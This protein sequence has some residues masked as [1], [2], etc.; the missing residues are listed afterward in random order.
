MKLEEQQ[1]E[2]LKQ[3]N[4]ALIHLKLE[5]GDVEIRKSALLRE[6]DGVRTLMLEQEQELVKEYVPDAV[7]N[8]QTG[9]VTQKEN[10]ST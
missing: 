1:F 7:I 3:L 10:E 6:I 8:M 9:E 2:K 4:T 5:I